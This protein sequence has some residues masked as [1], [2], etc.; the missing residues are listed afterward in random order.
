MSG[1]TS[2]PQISLTATGFVAPPESAILAGYQ[3]DQNAA[4]G[5]NVNPT[6]TT[7]LGQQAV[8]DTAIIGDS[9]NQQCLLF[10]SVDPAYAFGRMQDAIARIYFLTRIAGQPTVLQVACGGGVGVVIQVGAKISDAAGNLYLCTTAGVIPGGGTITLPFAAAV[11]GPIPVPQ[12]SGVA[13]YQAIPTW[14]TVSVVSGVVGQNVETRSAFEARRA[15]SVAKNAAGFLAA[16][17]GNVLSVPGVIDAY[18]TENFTGTAAVIGGVT[19][20]ANSLYVCVA[21]GAS[22][23]VAL[24]IWQKKNPGC[25]YT[26]NTTVTITDPNPGFGPGPPTYNVTFQTAT[27]VAISFTVTIANSASV[28]SN[29]GILISNAINTAFLGMDGGT[30]AR[31]GST[32]LASRFY[33]QIALLGSWAQ[34]I[35]IQ[36]GA[37]IPPDVS[38]TGSISGTTLTVSA[39]AQASFTGT[40]S[41]TNLTATAVTGTIYPGYLVSGTGVPVGTTIVSQTSG[42]TGGAGVYVTSASTT[43]I[44]ASLVAKGV[45]APGQFVYGT[46]VLTGSLITAQLTGTTGS[47]GTYTV[48]VNQ[49]VTSEAMT[50]VLPNQNSVTMAIN[51]IPTF[52]AYNPASGALA[53]VNLVLV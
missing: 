25:G 49:T 38:F 2:V 11:L 42:T 15:A 39:I 41:G 30:R 27:A 18:A 50:A 22:S 32:I 6:L 21:G 1:T 20:A 5:G 8:S 26:G 35:S 34:I 51:Q 36:I 53:D 12:S 45:M 47:T 43:A 28:P 46:N 33:G 44:A 52:A 14:N 4:F 9:Y 17:Y 48:A 10:N 37:D 16:I 29:A 19:I 24:A 7:G 40:G 13:I 3:A 23:A 31:I